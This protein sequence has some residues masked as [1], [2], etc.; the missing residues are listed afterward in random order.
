M[1]H[2]CF[3]FWLRLLAFYNSY[4]WYVHVDANNCIP[5]E[6]KKKK[7]EVVIDI[8]LGEWISRKDGCL[9]FQKSCRPH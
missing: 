4:I 7:D 2:F 9:M 5:A 3:V 6:K 1:I 8:L